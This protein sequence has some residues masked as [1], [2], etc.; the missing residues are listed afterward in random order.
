MVKSIKIANYVIITITALF[1]VMFSVLYVSNS[2][3]KADTSTPTFTLNVSDF[4]SVDED[5]NKIDFIYG[6]T[7]PTVKVNFSLT[8]ASGVTVASE[9][10]SL[11]SGSSSYSLT[12]GNSYILKLNLPTYSTTTIIL[13]YSFGER[14]KKNV[15]PSTNSGV[16]SF[17]APE[18]LT[19]LD[20][21]V[22]FNSI[23]QET[24]FN[25]TTYI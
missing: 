6:E 15:T 1:L 17:I 9:A 11:D 12:I 13:S 2:N 7:Y 14:N 18:N 10:L 8:D 5:E 22:R 4:R 16:I 3:L 21:T 24:W 19:S 23:S 20:V 25:G